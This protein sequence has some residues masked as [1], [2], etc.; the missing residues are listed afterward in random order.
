MQCKNS[1]IQNAMS[2]IFLSC[3]ILTW[4]KC[5]IFSFVFVVVTM[6][7]LI[8]I[9]AVSAL[10]TDMKKHLFCKMYMHK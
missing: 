8:L 5:L 2:N 3:C 1:K 6:Y 9:T 7:N 10:L 4:I